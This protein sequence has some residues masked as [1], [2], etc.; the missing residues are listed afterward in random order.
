MA[1]AHFRVEDIQWTTQKPDLWLSSDIAE[2]GHC[3]DCGTAL[4]MAYFLGPH[5]IAVNLGSIVQCDDPK[6][7]AKLEM[8]IFLKDKAAYFV[9]ADDGA[10]RSDE[11]MPSFTAK[12]QHWR[13]ANRTEQ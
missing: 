6:S 9:L 13:E 8:H 2:R 5:R 4:T 10:E 3:R 11:F 1:F 12:L 7:L